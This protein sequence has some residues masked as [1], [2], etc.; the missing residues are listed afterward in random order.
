MDG[1]ITPPSEIEST[2]KNYYG[3]SERDKRIDEILNIDNSDNQSNTSTYGLFPRRA[4]LAPDMLTYKHSL[5]LNALL[6]EENSI[7][8][9]SGEPRSAIL[10]KLSSYRDALQSF[11]E[12]EPFY[13]NYLAQ[14]RQVSP[15]SVK[16]IQDK[17]QDYTLDELYKLIESPNSDIEAL[18]HRLG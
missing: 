14:I 9:R 2:I 6:E 12:F 17:V 1:Y 11:K 10:D 8:E 3:G 16:K 4:K 18:G 13:L 15:E 7:L 5:E